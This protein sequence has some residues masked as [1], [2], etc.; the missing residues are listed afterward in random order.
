MCGHDTAILTL[1]YLIL[2]TL[3]FPETFTLIFPKSSSWPKTIYPEHWRKMGNVP[4]LLARSF[5]GAL[6][7]N[8]LLLYV[9]VFPI[10]NKF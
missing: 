7:K 5:S 2:F 6:V 10:E 8:C 3:W 9:A 4:I 1:L